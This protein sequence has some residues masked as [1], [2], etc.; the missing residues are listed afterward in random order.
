[1]KGNWVVHEKSKLLELLNEREAWK[2][3]LP[4]PV[5]VLDSARVDGAVKLHSQANDSDPFA[6]PRMRL[7]LKRGFELPSDILGDAAS[8]LKRKGHQAKGGN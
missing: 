6:G 1:M 3:P 5:P 2:L 8:A 7:H 4:Y